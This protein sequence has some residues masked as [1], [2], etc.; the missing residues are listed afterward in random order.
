[1]M[2]VYAPS[3][4]VRSAAQHGR[5]DIVHTLA[6]YIASFQAQRSP[7]GGFFGGRPG[8]SQ[9]LVREP[10]SKCYLWVSTQQMA[11]WM[12]RPSIC[13]TYSSRHL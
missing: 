5:L 7:F 9:D 4:Y 12:Q 2:V 3:W 8:A 10:G 6:P 1:M 11:G 13:S